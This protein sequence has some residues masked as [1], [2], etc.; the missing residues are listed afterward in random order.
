MNRKANRY[1]RRDIFAHCYLWRYES[2]GD[3]PER[4]VVRDVFTFHPRC[5]TANEQHLQ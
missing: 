1:Y 3:V 4:C 5:I 2:H